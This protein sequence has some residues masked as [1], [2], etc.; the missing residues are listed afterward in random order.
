MVVM[1][2]SP[3]YCILS[4][5]GMT[6]KALSICFRIVGLS[7]LFF[8]FPLLQ[9]VTLQDDPARNPKKWIQAA[10]FVPVRPHPPHSQCHES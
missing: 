8:I 1:I 6:L 2:T 7:S 9:M 4:V 5:S 10:E 3:S